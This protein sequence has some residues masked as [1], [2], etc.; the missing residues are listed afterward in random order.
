MPNPEQLQV[1]ENQVHQVI[2][3]ALEAKRT[4]MGIFSPDIPMPERSFIDLAKLHEAQIGD[5]LFALHALF[6]VTTLAFNQNT[7]AFFNRITKPSS[8]E[9]YYWLFQ[10]AVVVKFAQESPESNQIILDALDDYFTPAGYAGNAL[11]EWVHNCRVIMNDKNKGDLRN[12][13][14]QNDNDALKIVKALVV[15]ERTKSKYKPDFRRFGPKLAPLVIQW[16]NQYGLYRFTNVDKIGPPVDFQLSRVF[17]QTKGIIIPP[18][19]KEGAQAHYLMNVIL[20]PLLKTMCIANNLDP[21]LVS[22]ALYTIG[23]RLCGKRKHLECP[24]AS[25]CTRKMYSQKKIVKGRF[26]PPD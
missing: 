21:R 26:L 25:L 19:L 12:F 23:N 5:P 16:I 3:T 11:A 1:D 7:R 20:G 13:F 4:G 8:F 6:L 10:P 18:D 15:A 17:I 14:T 22:E 24:I 9:K 2:S